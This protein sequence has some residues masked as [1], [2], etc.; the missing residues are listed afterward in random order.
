MGKDSPLH[1]SYGNCI[2]FLADHAP[3]SWIKN[4]LPGYRHILDSLFND[5]FWHHHSLFLLELLRDVMTNMFNSIVVLLDDLSWNHVHSLLFPILCHTSLL[6]DFLNPCL[7]LVL[8]DFFLKRDIFNL[9]LTPHHIGDQ[10]WLNIHN[11]SLLDSFLSRLHWV[12]VGLEFILFFYDVDG[13]L[14]L[15]NQLIKELVCALWDS[16]LGHF[17]FISYSTI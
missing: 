3:L 5:L 8:D 16:I 17:I 14:R 12:W 1:M 10:L 11:F 9:R 6:W 13:V 7:V 15:F 4:Y 2:D